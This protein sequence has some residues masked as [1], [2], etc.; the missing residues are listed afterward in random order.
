MEALRTLNSQNKIKVVSRM[1]AQRGFPGR[2]LTSA[3]PRRP[4]TYHGGILQHVSVKMNRAPRLRRFRTNT[5]H[6]QFLHVA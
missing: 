1:L 6:S 3:S 2:E 5:L 4:W